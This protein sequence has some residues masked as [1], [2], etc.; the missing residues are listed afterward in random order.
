MISLGVAPDNT[1][2]AFGMIGLA[3][4][5][6]SP[7]A[8]LLGEKF[9]IKNVML[10]GLFTMSIGVF[11]IGPA[12]FFGF[13]PNPKQPIMYV[14]LFIDGF[15]AALMYIPTCPEII[16]ANTEIELGRIT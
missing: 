12:T 16:L 14:G 6:A 2:Y 8:G 3:T 15:A 11:L 7:L 10:C 5:F 13:M 4:V 9:P 1:G